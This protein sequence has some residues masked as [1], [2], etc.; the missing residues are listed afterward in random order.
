MPQER[1]PA[2]T[3]GPLTAAGPHARASAK[4]Q[5]TLINLGLCAGCSTFFVCW[6]VDPK[7]YNG[8]LSR[9][10][11][12]AFLRLGRL[13]LITGYLFLVLYWQESLALVE[14]LK[15]PEGYQAWQKHLKGAPNL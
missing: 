7:S 6:L 3:P 1:R 4:E 5:L 9:E 2:L 15:R 13:M 14:T 11:R 12:N 8:I 10:V